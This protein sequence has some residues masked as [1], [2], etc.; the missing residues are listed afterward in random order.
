M[1]NPKEGVRSSLKG[2]KLCV[3]QL[4]WFFFF[5]NL[6]NENSELNVEKSFC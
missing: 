5:F 3:E 4:Q 6:N 2:K 1:S